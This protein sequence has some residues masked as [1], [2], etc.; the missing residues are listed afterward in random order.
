[1]QKQENKE[2]C[3]QRC[4]AET[5]GGMKQLN[6]EYMRKRKSEKQQKHIATHPTIHQINRLK[7][8]ERQCTTPENT[9]PDAFV[10]AE[11]GIHYRVNASE[12]RI[13]SNTTGHKKMLYGAE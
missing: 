9:K 10:S 3:G 7:R 2:Q 1:M 12:D 11:V 13:V 5:T 6:V 4:R 8:K